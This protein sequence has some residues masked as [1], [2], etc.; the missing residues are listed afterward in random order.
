MK[1]RIPPSIENNDGYFI[2]P[3]IAGINNKGSK[4][5][6]RPAP[7]AIKLAGISLQ[8]KQINNRIRPIILPGI[9]KFSTLCSTSPTN[10]NINKI[11]ICKITRIPFI[12]N[13][14]SLY[15]E[16]LAHLLY[17]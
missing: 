5:S 1:N 10:E 4:A 2:I 14:L 12:K 13:K 8:D 3:T 17:L 16:Q 9:G 7:S 11:A 15:L 6:K